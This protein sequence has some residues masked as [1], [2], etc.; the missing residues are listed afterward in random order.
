MDN[1]VLKDTPNRENAIKLINFFLEP[2]NAAE[3]AIF[4]SHMSGAEGAMA[5]AS[6][7]IKQAPALKPQQVRPGISFRAVQTICRF[8]ATVSGRS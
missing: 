5:R 4:A 1:V 2:E 7:A 3:V 6:D 8:C